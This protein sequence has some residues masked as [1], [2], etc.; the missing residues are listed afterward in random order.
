M[1]LTLRPFQ[2]TAIDFL[3]RQ[4]RALLS[5][6]MRLGKTS[7]VLHHIHNVKPKSVI[8]VAPK[9][10]V[11]HSWIQEAI[12]WELNEVASKMVAII[13]TP[14]QRQALINDPRPY[15][16]ISWD[17]IADLANSTTDILVLDEITKAKS[18]LASR[19][20]HARSIQA[21]Q[22]IGLTGTTLANGAIDLFGQFAALKVVKASI[23]MTQPKRAEPK[24]LCPQ[25]L[26]WR[27]EYFQDVM[28]G[29]GTQIQKWEP[30]GNI[31]SILKPFKKHIFTLDAA[32]YNVLAP[33]NFEMHTVDMTPAERHNYISLSAMLNINLDGDTLIVNEGAKF[34]K[35]QTLC[36]G[37]IYDEAGQARR[38]KT[39]SK[40]TAVADFCESASAEGEAVLLF[41][42]FR[43]EAIW[44]SEL[45][46]Q[47]GLT[48]CSGSDKK[49]MDKWN[50]HEVNV[51]MMHPGST[52]GLNLQYG[53][54]ICVWSSITY[55]YEYWDQANARLVGDGQKKPVSINVFAAA[56]T[57]EQRQFE[58]IRKKVKDNKE[59]KTLTKFV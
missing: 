43:E 17:N 20:I 47:R 59:Y 39:S 31:D 58:A 6:D 16:I 34:A 45:L 41:Y 53:G 14:K 19:S 57:V 26:A 13:G 28:E 11:E 3:A 4:P 38:G 48:F 12:K 46:K 9:R 55:N 30:I 2:S 52:F 1:E 50:N 29:S 56:R 27:A 36:N 5:I 21:R 42:A 51:L 18:V 15:K 33:V 23:I 22:Y 44:L 32:D 8:I 40:L 54:H 49:F 10:V 24:P 25:F 7:I 35:L 37:F